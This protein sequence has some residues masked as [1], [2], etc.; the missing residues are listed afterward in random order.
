MYLEEVLLALTV[1]VRAACTVGMSP[2]LKKMMAFNTRCACVICP[3][4]VAFECGTTD[5]I[6]E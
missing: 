5:N 2:N 1:Q 4:I 6:L 3:I